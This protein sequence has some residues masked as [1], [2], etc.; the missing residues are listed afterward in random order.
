MTRR[1]RGDEEHCEEVAQANVDFMQA[2]G[3]QCQCLPRQDGT[4]LACID[5]CAYCNDDLTVCGVQSAQAIFDSDTGLRV[6]VGGVFE[7]VTGFDHPTVLAIENTNCIE[8]DD[9]IV[10]C[11]TCDVYVNGEKCK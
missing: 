2:V 7:Y 10:S 5:S 11:E 4:L 9:A 6:G 1:L 8:K 3:L